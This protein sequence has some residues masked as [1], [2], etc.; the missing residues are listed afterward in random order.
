MFG[1]DL[2]G[3]HMPEITSLVHLLPDRKVMEIVRPKKL[4]HD[5]TQLVYLLNRDAPEAFAR[6]R[7]LQRLRSE[8]YSVPEWVRRSR[9]GG[10]GGSSSII[11]IWI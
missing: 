8:V 6:E 11:I 9:R 2:D 5:A 4:G 3:F 10:D 1:S 7:V